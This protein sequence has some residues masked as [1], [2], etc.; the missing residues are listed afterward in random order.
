MKNYHGV[1]WSKLSKQEK[2]ELL[3][4]SNCIDGKTGN[5]I[6]SDGECI[7]D[8]TENLSVAGKIKNGEIKIHGQSIIYDPSE[9]VPT[10]QEK[11]DNTNTEQVKLKLN[12]K[13]DKDILDRLLDKRE[14]KQ[15]YIKALIR[16]DIK[17]TKNMSMDEFIKYR[18][19]QSK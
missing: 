13:T 18:Q 4:N 8:L 3:K 7:I 14:N 1:K 17:A 15:G 16:A 9:G 19:E 6:T 10:A 5:N 2:E 12:K 11:Y